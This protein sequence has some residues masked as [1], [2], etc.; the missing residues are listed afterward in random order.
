MTFKPPAQ[1]PDFSSLFTSLAQT[2]AKQN[3]EAMFQT[4]KLLIEWISQFQQ[5]VVKKLKD[6]EDTIAGLPSG[7]SGFGPPGADG[8][9]GEDGS[10]GPPG[11]A[12]AASTIAGP[13][14][15]Q[16]NSGPPGIDGFDSEYNEPYVFPGPKGDTG[17]SGA[18][19]AR[20]ADGPPGLDGYCECEPYIIPGPV[21]LTGATGA[22]GATGPAGSSGPMGMDGEDGQDSFIPGPQGVAGS[23]SAGSFALTNFTQDLGAGDSAGNFD[24]TG[25]AGLTVDKNVLVV[26][27]AQ[28]I[29]SKGDARDEFEMN[30]ILTTGYVVDAA[31]IRVYWNCDDIVVGIYAFAYMVSG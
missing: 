4:I 17:T 10:I 24:I 18:A 27:T 5:I 21:G 12:G 25:L 15:A 1:Q 6:D 8:N 2:K 30:P 7:A 26:Q 23:A 11:P 19:G 20:G 3:D 29:A 14:G 22:T 31:T 16:G 28:K 13:T 9:D